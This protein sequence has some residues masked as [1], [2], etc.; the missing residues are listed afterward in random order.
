MT[1]NKKKKE[2]TLHNLLSRVEY[3]RPWHPSYNGDLHLLPRSSN[4][5]SVNSAYYLSFLDLIHPCS[6]YRAGLSLLIHYVFP[7]QTTR[8]RFVFDDEALV[9]FLS[10]FSN[11]C[12]LLIMHAQI[13]SNKSDKRIQSHDP[14]PCLAG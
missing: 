1:N 9:C 10:S 5:A 2:K 13:T 6:I 11:C 8:V 14:F 4:R 3:T 12:T 7:L